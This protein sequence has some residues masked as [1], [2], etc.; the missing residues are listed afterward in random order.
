MAQ[1]TKALPGMIAEANSTIRDGREDTALRF[2]NQLEVVNPDQVNRVLASKVGPRIKAVT[3]DPPSTG[4]LNPRRFRT[5]RCRR[6]PDWRQPAARTIR[7]LTQR[8]SPDDADELPR[9]AIEPSLRRSW[10]FL[11]MKKLKAAVGRAKM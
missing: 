5:A 2:R 8:F 11:S 1:M 6:R 9:G 10:L 3:S 7:R 4:R